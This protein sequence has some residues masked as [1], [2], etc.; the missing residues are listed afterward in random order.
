MIP[1]ASLNFRADKEYRASRRRQDTRM[2]KFYK[3]FS[4]ITANRS[5]LYHFLQAS[6]FRSNHTSI[7]VNKNKKKV[8]LEYGLGHEDYGELPNQQGNDDQGKS[9]SDK[10][11]L[12]LPGMEKSLIGPGVIN[13]WSF[14]I[15]RTYPTIPYRVL[16][17]VLVNCPC[18]QYMDLQ[19]MNINYDIRLSSSRKISCSSDADTNDPSITSQEYLKCVRFN[20]FTPTR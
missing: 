5:N 15:C 4:A 19:G 17:Y 18:L 20:G 1:K 8:T 9:I 3:M 7:N 10:F 16:K 12:P 14:I 13:N 11:E 6:D 2:T